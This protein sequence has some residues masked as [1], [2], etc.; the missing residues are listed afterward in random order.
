VRFTRP[1][2]LAVLR[3]ISQFKALVNSIP[4]A[5]TFEQAC[6]DLLEGR[7][8]SVHPSSL[9]E[10]GRKVHDALHLLVTMPANVLL[11]ERVVLAAFDAARAQNL[12]DGRPVVTFKR[13][14]NTT[15]TLPTSSS[16]KPRKS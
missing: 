1:K 13:A 8:Q 16:K 10:L 6:D 15:T 11:W 12:F 7:N 3:R 4:V 2:S 14:A 5:S 9:V